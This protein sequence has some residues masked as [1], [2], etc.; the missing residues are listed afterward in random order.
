MHLT[1]F[2]DSIIFVYI[3]T[4][5]IKNLRG[6]W[7]CSH[8]GGQ[9]QSRSTSGPAHGLSAIGVDQKAAPSEARVC[10]VCCVKSAFKAFC[11]F[12]LA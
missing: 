10:T 2:L 3:I 11:H 9:Q 1:V 7:S 4:I 12:D 5:S 6:R 8:W